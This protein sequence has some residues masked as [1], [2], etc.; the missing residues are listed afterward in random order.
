MGSNVAFVCVATAACKAG[1][2]P[3]LATLGAL[4]ALT[5]FLF[6]WKLVALRRLLTPA[7]GVTVMMLMALSVAPVVWGMLARVPAGFETGV[8]AATAVLCTFIPMIL[9]SLTGKGML[10][11]WAPVIGVLTGSAVGYASGMVQADAVRSA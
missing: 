1:G 2:M 3:L 11:L 9:L 7:V 6:T 5:T 4:S 10:R 8:A